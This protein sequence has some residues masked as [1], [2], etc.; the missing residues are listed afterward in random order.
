M[1]TSGPSGPSGYA[2]IIRV[3]SAATTD[4]AFQSS[5]DVMA[6]AIVTLGGSITGGGPRPLPVHMGLICFLLLFFL[7]NGTKR[8]LISHNG[9]KS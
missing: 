5:T 4:C 2:S 9:R 1:V 7:L 6:H 8:H 3:P